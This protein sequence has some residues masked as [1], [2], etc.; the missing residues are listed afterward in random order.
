M[1][2]I[3]DNR[4]VS[5]KTF[6]TRLINFLKNIQVSDLM[7]EEEL[8]YLQNVGNKLLKHQIDTCTDNDELR[9]LKINNNLIK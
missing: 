5:D 7:G 9:Y 4:L 3:I 1:T 6:A 2:P 8:E